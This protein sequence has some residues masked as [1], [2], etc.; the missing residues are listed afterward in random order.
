MFYI[1]LT[2]PWPGAAVLRPASL[3]IC[4]VCLCLYNNIGGGGG[5]V[6]DPGR[7]HGGPAPWLP[8]KI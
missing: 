3:V 7:D 8:N 2:Q 5:S 1:A 6:A 4:G